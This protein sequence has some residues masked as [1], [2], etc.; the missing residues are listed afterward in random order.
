MSNE[1]AINPQ[2]YRGLEIDGH[3]IQCI[4]MIEVLDLGFH[5]GNALKYAWRFGRKGVTTT[6]EPQ[7]ASIMRDGSFSTMFSKTSVIDHDQLLEDASK[8][9]WYLDRWRAQG[10][11]RRAMREAMQCNVNLELSGYLRQMISFAREWSFKHLTGSTFDP[12]PYMRE[13]VELLDI[14]SDLIKHVSR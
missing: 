6:I 3:E 8:C 11:E 2:H 12:I 14:K 1:D 5:L 7:S 10:Y 9:E 4:D 13:L